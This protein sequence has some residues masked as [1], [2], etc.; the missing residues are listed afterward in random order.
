[1]KGFKLNPNRDYVEKIIDGIYRKDGHCPC[2][3]KVDYTT[4]CPCDKF[5]HEGK[6]CCKLYVPIDKD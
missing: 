5:I 2:Q 3:L 6:C 1:M 4:L